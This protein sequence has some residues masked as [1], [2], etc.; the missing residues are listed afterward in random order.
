MTP[1]KAE[2]LEQAKE[3]VQS[4]DDI[5]LSDTDAV[6]VQLDSVASAL[7]DLAGTPKRKK[8]AKTLSEVLAELVEDEI[9]DP[10]AVNIADEIANLIRTK[11]YEGYSE[12]Y[13]ET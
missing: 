6:D 7:L 5:D 10:A 8:K 2:D 12:N 13:V 9:A 1:I 4:L 3:A 11:D